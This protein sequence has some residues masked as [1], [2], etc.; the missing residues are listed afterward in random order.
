[1][2]SSEFRVEKQK[3]KQK[4]NQKKTRCQKERLK[5]E[6]VRVYKRRHIVGISCYYLNLKSGLKAV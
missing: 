3:E 5:E 6:K 1:M 2:G 4:R